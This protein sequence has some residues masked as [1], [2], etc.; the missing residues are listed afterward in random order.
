M[1]AELFIKQLLDAGPAPLRAAANWMEMNERGSAENE[2]RLALRCSAAAKP[3]PK[4]Q[5]GAEV[6]VDQGPRGVCTVQWVYPALVPKVKDDLTI[7]SEPG[8][9]YEVESVTGERAQAT[10]YDLEYVEAGT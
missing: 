10:E 3:E 7:G 8:Y 4:F 5:P 9:I 2:L 6:F 1:D